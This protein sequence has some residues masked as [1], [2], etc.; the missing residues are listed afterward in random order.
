L[1]GVYNV[2]F[3]FLGLLGVLK[4]MYITLM[5]TL[6]MVLICVDFGGDGISKRQFET[7]FGCVFGNQIEMK[8]FTE[9]IQF[10]Q[11][12]NGRRFYLEDGDA[13]MIIGAW[14]SPS[15][16]VEDRQVTCISFGDDE[17]QLDCGDPSK[18]VTLRWLET[19]AVTKVAQGTNDGSL[20]GRGT[21]HVIFDAKYGTT[22]SINVHRDGRWLGLKVGDAGEFNR[23]IGAMPYWGI[24]LYG[25]DVILLAEEGN[26]PDT[27]AYRFVFRYISN[28]SD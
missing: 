26:G 14:R 9:V 5:V 11:A 13:Q 17:L 23:L 21:Q 28:L 25:N 4:K 3:C 10:V 6:W 27:V 8:E 7:W 19:A 1:G 20:R 16:S 18:T 12:E 15:G 24:T 2:F 22:P